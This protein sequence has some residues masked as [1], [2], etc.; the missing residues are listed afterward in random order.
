MLIVLHALMYF[1]TSLNQKICIHILNS[2]QT[3]PIFTPLN[4]EAGQTPGVTRDSVNSSSG[5]DFIAIMPS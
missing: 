4:L 5:K 2:L 3:E 1:S